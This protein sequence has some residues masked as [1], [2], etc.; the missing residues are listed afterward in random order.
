ML[1]RNFYLAFRR[2]V[3]N[4]LMTTLNFAGL[5]LSLAATMLIG[6]LVKKEWQTDAFVPEGERVFRVIR[7]SAVDG[8]PYSIG[9]T[10]PNFAPALQTDFAGD[11][12]E[13]TRFYPDEIFISVGDKRFNEKK[14]AY[15]DPNFFRFFGLELSIGDAASA[16]SRP[17][18]VVLTQETATRLFGSPEAAMGK[19]IRWNNEQDLEVTGIFAGFPQNTHLDFDYV[20]ALHRFQH[21]EWYKEWWNNCL[22]TYVRLKPEAVAATMSASLPA[23]IDKYFGKDIA[24]HGGRIDLTLQPLSDVY[25][26]AD[27]RYD[28]VQHGNQRATRIFA[29]A[30]LLLLVI[31]CFNFIN[32]STSQ[33]AERSREV[34]VRKTLGAGR[35]ELGQQ[36]LTESFLLVSASVLAAGAVTTL[37]LPSFNVWFD[38]DL[39]LSD[40]HSLEIAAWLTGITLLVT[41]GAGFYPSFLMAGFRPAAVLKHKARLSGSAVLVRRALTVV[42]FALSISLLV[43][44]IVVY[45]QL[46]FIRQADLG[47]NREN[48][49]VI[50]TYGTD[51]RR[52]K[53]FSYRQ[54]IGQYPGVLG[55]SVSDAAPGITPDASIMEIKGRSDRPKMNVLYADFEFAQTYGLSLAAG[56]HFDPLLA[57]DTASAV[58][59][60]ETACRALGVT[61]EQA[62]GIDIRPVFFD[63][64][65]HRVVGVLKDY[66]FLSLREKIAPLLI[67]PN[68]RM[69]GTLAVRV[70]AGQLPKTIAQLQADWAEID[71]A[72]PFEYHMLDEGLERLYR[73]EQK[74]GKLFAFFALAAIFIACLGMF[75]LAILLSTQRTKEIGIRKVLGA[76]VAGITALLATDFLKLVLLAI[77]IASPIAWYF[78]QN[79]LTD[80]AYRIEIQWWMFVVSGVVALAI[81]FITV[82]FQ[83]VKAA[84]TN[85]VQSLRSE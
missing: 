4:R 10:A 23:F 28:P 69:P 40:L 72:H 18:A 83:S 15:A 84:L 26:Q 21:E 76:S 66:H 65:S 36:F 13:T 37:V 62:I 16:L 55:H 32:L 53:L 17:E 31:A 52:E 48:V 11:V 71:P 27:T 6:M 42:Q 64:L 29:L 70:A 75:G 39:K 25:W 77:L 33:A 43:S 58:L 56:R 35:S 1:H 20:G 60:N 81:A 19:I 38:L 80:F 45:R 22:C 12:E 63:S 14:F 68:Y 5:S 73:S 67:L 74:L 47:F 50:E 9:V 78:M 34:G 2:L 44:T 49:V 24:E 51:V 82:G 8:K 46:E 7:S 41:L 61:P 85:P 57:T 30:A 54:K 3:K 59:L 79:W